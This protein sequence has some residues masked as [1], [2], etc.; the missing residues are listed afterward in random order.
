MVPDVI[1]ISNIKSV[2]RQFFANI[3]LFNPRGIEV[4]E[5]LTAAKAQPHKLT[6]F[7][8]LDGTTVTYPESGTSLPLGFDGP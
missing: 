6:P 3:T 7:A 8:R 2:S 1:P 4:N 5:I